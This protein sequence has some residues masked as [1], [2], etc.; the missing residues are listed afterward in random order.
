M[1]YFIIVV[2]PRAKAIRSCIMEDKGAY[3]ERGKT[4]NGVCMVVCLSMRVAC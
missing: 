2:R 3:I 4:K 1:S